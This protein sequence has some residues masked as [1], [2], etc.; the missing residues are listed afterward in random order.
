MTRLSRDAPNAPPAKT[1]QAA[2]AAIK[3]VRIFI[4]FLPGV[5][6]GASLSSS[7]AE[8]LRRRA[9]CGLHKSKPLRSSRSEAAYIELQGRAKGPA[10]GL[11]QRDEIGDRVG[12]IHRI[13]EAGESHLRPG[14]LLLR[15]H[16]IDLQGRNVPG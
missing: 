13:G 8:S 11:F 2:T 5:G 9:S 10:P 14:H 7:S 15:A 6:E 16:Q 4:L 1:A 3:P 12:F